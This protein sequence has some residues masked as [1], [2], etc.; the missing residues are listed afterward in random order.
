MA[1]GGEYPFSLTAWRSDF[2]RRWPVGTRNSGTGGRVRALAGVVA[3][4]M[5][6]EIGGNFRMFEGGVCIDE[7]RQTARAERER[8]QPDE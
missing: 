2:T 7:G 1:N 8:G 5:L 4:L 6:H 3:R